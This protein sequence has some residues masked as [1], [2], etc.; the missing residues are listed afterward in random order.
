MVKKLVKPNLVYFTFWDT[1][2]QCYFVDRSCAYIH[3]RNN[4]PLA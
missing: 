4:N 3:I 2:P 1:H